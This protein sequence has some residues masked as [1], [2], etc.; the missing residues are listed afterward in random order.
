MAS[1]A[2]VILAS[3]WPHAGLKGLL[4]YCIQIKARFVNRIHIIVG[5]QILYFGCRTYLHLHIFVTFYLLVQQSRETVAL[6]AAM[7]Q[8][9]D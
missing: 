6:T 4:L 5:N 1:Q 9:K 3:T 7:L 2:D 8:I